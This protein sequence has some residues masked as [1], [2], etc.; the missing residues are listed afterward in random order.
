MASLVDTP[1]SVRRILLIKLKHIGDSLLLTATSQ[2]LRE[3]YPEAEIS[4]LVRKGTEGI[5][6]GA[7]SIDR[8]YTCM[9]PEVNL[10]GCREW[11]HEWESVFELWWRPFDVAIE[12]TRGD[13]GRWRALLVRATSKASYAAPSGGWFWK[14]VF[15][16][17]GLTVEKQEHAV[18]KDFRLV[19]TCLGI[20]Q[21]ASPGLEFSEKSSDFS[22]TTPSHF[23]LLHPSTRWKRK[24]WPAESWAELARR[25]SGKGYK[26]ILS[27]GP[28]SDEVNFCHEILEG[29]DHSAMSYTGGN[30]NWAQLAGIMRQ[31]QLFVGVDTA[32]M[33][34][35]A[36]CKVH[37][38]ALFLPWM[39]S[40]WYPWGTEHDIIE[41]EGFPVRPTAETRRMG[42]GMSA[43]KAISVDRVVEVVEKRLTR[44]QGRE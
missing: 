5:L 31:A 1:K 10:R 27:S 24:Q 33:H 30:L 26:M 15:D 12:L 28:G 23:I 37:C 39:S 14:H 2:S 13:R 18:E 35:A 29:A 19:S 42:C 11:L 7:E 36:A 8:I 41:A 38:V 16:S 44:K 3:C 21:P 25:L 20:N 43:M 40:S 34:L 22:I 32:A 4:V 9:P 6:A 17:Y